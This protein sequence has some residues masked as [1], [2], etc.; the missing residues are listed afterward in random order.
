MIG[1]FTDRDT[2]DLARDW[3][4]KNVP[5]GGSL[6]FIGTPWYFSPPLSPLFSAPSPKVRLEA[7]LAVLEPHLVISQT[8]WDPVVSASR[9]D[10][11]VVSELESR[12][13]VRVGLP[14]S[15]PFFDLWRV[16][17]SGR[18]FY[19]KL[20][21]SLSHIRMDEAPVD[22]LYTCPSTTVYKRI[23]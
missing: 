23:K 13:A 22:W 3:I 4:V 12:D 15:K 1:T 21:W 18:T 5:K 7:G 14:A 8:E 11:F 9:P 20:H 2:R 16:D 10:Y 17:Y 19:P 6:G